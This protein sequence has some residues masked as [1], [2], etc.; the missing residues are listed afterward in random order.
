MAYSFFLVFV[1]IGNDV[2]ITIKIESR[3][4]CIT[5]LFVLNSLLCI[6][7]TRAM[8]SV[9]T[10][11]VGDAGPALKQQWYNPSSHKFIHHQSCM[12]YKQSIE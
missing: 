10:N 8:L 3:Y 12:T 11:V 7:I 5:E 4:R 2:K 6:C 9:Y 1:I